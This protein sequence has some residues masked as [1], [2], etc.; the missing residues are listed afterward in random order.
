MTNALAIE[1]VPRSALSAAHAADILALCERAYEEPFEELL[2][3]FADAT[4]VL[5]FAD[6]QLV[7]H[8]L[9]VPRVLYTPERAL[10]TAYVEAVATEPTQQKR[11]YATATLRALATQI[12]SYD[13]AALSPSD[14]AFYA[15]LGW[16]PWT[17]PLSVRL[18]EGDVPTPD[19]EVMIMR[20]PASRTIDVTQPLIASWREFD[21]W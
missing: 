11:G 20:L 8:A 19:E 1:V 10:H 17:G 18:P 9:W 12:T 14:E 16:E 21:I 13:I 7:S 3:S 6:A 5:A 4:H 2:A 15:R